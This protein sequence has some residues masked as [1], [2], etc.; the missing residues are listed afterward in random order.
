MAD[1]TKVSGCVL[2]RHMQLQSAQ[3][4]IKHNYMGKTA[5]KLVVGW[6]F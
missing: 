4:T 2:R 6:D 1:K 3:Y 5:E